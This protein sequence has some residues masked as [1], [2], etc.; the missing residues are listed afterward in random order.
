MKKHRTTGLY[1]QS[2]NGSVSSVT[3]AKALVKQCQDS[4]QLCDILSWA[5]YSQEHD[6]WYMKVRLMYLC[7][8]GGVIMHCRKECQIGGHYVAIVLQTHFPKSSYNMMTACH[9]FKSTLNKNEWKI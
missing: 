6:C 8:L 4:A 2:E 1:R 9:K 5:L 7:P 3:T